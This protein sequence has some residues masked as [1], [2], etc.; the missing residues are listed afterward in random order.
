MFAE[1]RDILMGALIRL[2]EPSNWSLRGT[3]VGL[4]SFPKKTE[5]L[6]HIISRG[7]SKEAKA[8]SADLDSLLHLALHYKVFQK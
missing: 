6:S 2:L 8:H 5:T 7:Q 4:T 1:S 3:T